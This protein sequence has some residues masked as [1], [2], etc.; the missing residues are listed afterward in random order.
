[1]AAILP[2]LI[3]GSVTLAPI[4]NWS[5]TLRRL[6]EGSKAVVILWGVLM[7]AATISSFLV[8]FKGIFP[9]VVGGQV[10]YCPVGEDPRCSFDAVSGG[11]L[12]L[13][14][15]SH[16][17]LC[18]CKSTCGVVSPD[19]AP[20]RKGSNLQALLLDDA[21]DMITRTNSYTYVAY[22]D[23]VFL[24]F[25]IA[26]GVFGVV[27]ARWTQAR[28]RNGVFRFLNGTTSRKMRTIFFLGSP[29]NSI[30]RYYAAKFIASMFFGNAILAAIIC[31][32]LFVGSLIINE[33]A[34]W[35]WPVRYEQSSKDI[36]H[37]FQC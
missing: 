27:E 28:V 11:S 3:A 20:L 32:P 13:V 37:I 6:P 2:V 23:E 22:V 24:S 7:Y 1:L 35:N 29:S 16:Y 15:L 8:A 21:L 36:F 4:L 33:L 25:I 30:L 9:F 17:N 10:A 34:L 19:H 18:H 12:R 5:Y 31:P 26:H 14:S